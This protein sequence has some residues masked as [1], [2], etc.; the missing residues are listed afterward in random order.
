MKKLI[1]TLVFLFSFMTYLVPS[2][3]STEFFAPVCLTVNG[4]YVKT[5]NH[6]YLKKGTT[7]VSL[8]DLGEIFGAEV[9]WNEKTSTAKIE[10]GDKTISVTKGKKTATVNGKTHKLDASAVIVNGRTYVP[11][12]FLAENLG[13]EVLW[14]EK[15]LTANLKSGSASVPAHL[16]GAAPFT[17]DELYWLSKIVSAEASGE[18]NSGKVAVAN[19]ILNRV[20]SNEFPNTIYGVI[21]DK[22]YGVQF[23][24]IADGSIYKN[25][26]TDSVTAAKRALL[27]EDVSR[28]SLY[29]LN[30]K[31]ATNSW[32]IKN[33]R[34][35]KTIGNHD[36]YL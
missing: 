14:N 2:G 23:T 25:P 24:P 17:E 16:K 6:A 5:Q 28:E 1:L 12:R 3:A 19:V 21:F 9:S 30:P 13:A 27:G 26:T 29:F 15:T 36:F 31:T 34:F 8:R 11:L 10:N 32:I 4:A 18:I 35:F 20:E 33:R 7:I 22:K